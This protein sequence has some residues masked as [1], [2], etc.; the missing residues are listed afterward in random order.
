[1]LKKLK[2]NKLIV[3]LLFSLIL[4]SLIGLGITNIVNAGELPVLSE[5]SSIKE[6]NKT[7]KTVTIF[8]SK[9]SKE[10][11][12]IKLDT[13]LIVKVPVGYQKVAEFTLDSYNLESINPLEKISFYNLNKDSSEISGKEYDYKYWGSYP[14][15]DYSYICDEEK[16]NCSS[17]VTGSHLEYGWLDYNSSIILKGKYRVSI[18]TDVHLGDK[19]EWVPTYYGVEIKEWAVYEQSSGSKYYVDIG[20][21][22]YT[23][24]EFTSD[25]TFNLTTSVNVTYLIV[26]GGGGGGTVNQGGGGGAGGFLTGYMNMSGNFTVDVGLGG[27]EH[28][29]GKNSSLNSTLLAWGGGDGGSG[30]QNGGTGGSG[31]G[32]GWNGAEPGDSISG[33]GNDG[34]DGNSGDYADGRG[35]AGGGGASSAGGPS[36]A[37]LAGYGGNGSSS[38]INGTVVYYSGGGGGGALLTTDGWGTSQGLG[39]SGGGGNG[40]LDGTVAQSGINGTG[41]GGGGSN[42]VAGAG[43]GGSGIIILRMKTSDIKPPA[44]DA[45]PPTFTTIPANASLDYKVNWA[46]VTFVATDETGF[47]TF[48]V[49]DTRFQ[50]NSTG[51]LS[52]KTALAADTYRL[53]ITINDTIN[54]INYTIYEVEI[55]K[56]NINGVDIIIDDYG[57]LYEFTYPQTVN[58]TLVDKNTGDEDCVYTSYRNG[59]Q[60]TL[61]ENKSLS[62][63]FYVYILNSTGGQ[64]YSSIS[65]I[66]YIEL[67]VYNSTDNCQVLFNTT[68]P[69]E[70]G[71]TFTVYTDCT[72]AY[73]LKRNGTI[74]TNNSEQD[75]AV[76]TYNFSVQRTDTVNYTNIYDDEYFTLSDTTAPIITITNPTEGETEY[77]SS[78]VLSVTTD[79]TST[80]A[81]SINE[82]SNISLGTGTSFSQTLSLIDGAYTIRVFCND[83]FTNQSLTGE[84]VTFSVYTLGGA[85]DTGAGGGGT[86][87]T[88]TITLDH[89]NITYDSFY[90]NSSRYVYVIPLDIFDN[91]VN[92]TNIS[93]EVLGDIN[94]KEGPIMKLVDGRYRKAI[95]IEEF[96]ITS[97][98]VKFTVS[99]DLKVIN[100][101]V[102]IPIQDKTDVEKVKETAKEY[103]NKVINYFKDNGLILAIVLIIA[104]F[105]ILVFS[106]IIY[107]FKKDK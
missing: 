104:F 80:C 3:I 30:N 101:I 14:V 12:T 4:F 26:G 94:Y 43:K 34:G 47:D 35:A 73:T 68:S 7:T 90:F 10:V 25:G 37:D 8:D 9:D 2:N 1:M 15:D 29:A 55:N 56:I 32:A 100:E 17:V 6:Y 87:G 92:I 106:L 19:V 13:P 39:G 46:G 31:G 83:S 72:S 24:L 70:Y 71:K 61:P 20:G 49:N 93:I 62:P 63:G 23:I 96:N 60:L 40:S 21:V 50:I 33:Q 22:N 54:N 97:F 74:I 11:A 51:Y 41:G 79:E 44:V 64:N 48:T 65:D 78:V 99:Q 5:F 52:N 18:W 86:F 67:N 103:V 59:T 81:Y 82:E 57:L 75:L 84:S 27:D 16:I 42:G 76:G 66:Q 53:N 88:G 89:I 85:V 58:A 36:T 45:T 38:S 107:L 105:V 95:N 98:D 69:L 28:V 102:T 91:V 77:S